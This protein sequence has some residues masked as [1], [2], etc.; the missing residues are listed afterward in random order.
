MKIEVGKYYKMRNGV[1]AFVAAK[2]PEDGALETFIGTHGRDNFRWFNDGKVVGY[3]T[4]FYDIIEEWREPKKVKID[5]WLNV[6]NN[7]SHA[8]HFTKSAADHYKDSGRIA[9]IHIEREV[10]EGEGL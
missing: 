6:Y 10:V 4:D 1:R 5:C 3:S 2:L 8:H 7:G 9:C